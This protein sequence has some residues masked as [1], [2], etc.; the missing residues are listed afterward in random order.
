MELKIEFAA[1]HAANFVKIA[2]G[3]GETGLDCSVGSIAVLDRILGSFHD[4]GSKPD[5][6]QGTILVASCYLGEIMRR[7]AG[8]KWLDG[9]AVGDD[10][11]EVMRFPMIMRMGSVHLVPFAKV[12]KRIENGNEDS[13]PKAFM[14]EATK[15]Q[16]AKLG[17]FRKLFG[18][19]S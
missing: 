1:E 3:Q 13:L 8:A 15:A 4:G 19:R 11:P 7:E 5:E 2:Q 10:V 6:M 18:R 16:T 14:S 17:F 12:C 9:E